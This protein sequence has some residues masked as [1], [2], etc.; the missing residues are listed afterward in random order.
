MCFTMSVAHQGVSVTAVYEP[1][2]QHSQG[3]R[4]TAVYEPGCQHSHVTNFCVL[5]SS[6]I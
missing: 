6:D 2:C 5:E 4:V 3:V 1:G